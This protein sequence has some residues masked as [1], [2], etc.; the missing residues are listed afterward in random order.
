LEVAVVQAV[1]AL[2]R[3]I[4]YLY[5]TLLALFLLALSG[6]ALANGHWLHLEM[7]P[8]SGAALT[9][10]LLG[11]ALVG[12]LAVALAV[13]RVFPAL[14]LLWSLVVLVMLIKGYIF[15]GYYFAQ[16]ELKTAV[17]LIGGA[18]VALLG[19]WSSA[20]RPTARA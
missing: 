13:K 20:M 1:K 5:H 18:F 19:A 6:M 16:G 15:S 11:G 9:Y 8:W 12:L 3:I 10:W 14:L 7:L 17:W 2:M 4:G